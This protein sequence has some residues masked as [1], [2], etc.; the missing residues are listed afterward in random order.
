M[1]KKSSLYLVAKV[2]LTPT[3]L[4]AMEFITENCILKG[5]SREH[6]VKIKN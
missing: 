4:L 1:K 5:R 2:T 6:G 3:G